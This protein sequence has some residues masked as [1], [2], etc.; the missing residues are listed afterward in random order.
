MVIL[1]GHMAFVLEKF[2]DYFRKINKDLTGA[3]LPKGVAVPLY[4]SSKQL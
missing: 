1:H 2:I 3:I 4:E